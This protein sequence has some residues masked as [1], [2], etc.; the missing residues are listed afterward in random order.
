MIDVVD[1]S[2]ISLD[3]HRPTVAVEFLAPTKES[4]DIETTNL[5]VNYLVSRVESLNLSIY[6]GVTATY[7]TGTIKQLEGS[8]GAGSLKE[9][10]YDNSVFGLGPGLLASFLMFEKNK[11]SIHINGGGNVVIYNKNFPAGGERYNFMWRVGPMLE[12]L[13]AASNSIGISYHLAHVSNGQGV[14]AQN[15]SYDAQ[16]VALRFSTFF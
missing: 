5:D 11:L 12:Y 10:V 4:S 8:L 3:K 2:Q 15:P 9:V 13:I 6:L 16:G 1:A 14:G 7:V